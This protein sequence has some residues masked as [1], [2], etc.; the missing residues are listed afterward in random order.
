MLKKKGTGIVIAAV[1]ALTLSTGAVFATEADQGNTVLPKD[2]IVDARETISTIKAE[3]SWQETAKKNAK[4]LFGTNDFF[5]IYG[6][7]RYDTSLATADKLKQ[8]LGCDKYSTII[9]ASGETYPDALSGSLLAFA[10][11]APILLVSNETKTQDEIL[12]YIENN[13]NTRGRVYLLGGEG[14]VSRSFEQGVR[15]IANVKRLGGVDRYE[16][17]LAILNEFPFEKENKIAALV[18]SGTGF[19]DCLSASAADYPFYW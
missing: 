19:A 1:M 14:A 16:T 10:Y 18:C 5:R 17:N 3:T 7:D 9:M 4:R 12:H 13:L 11:E 8:C 2:C 6:E 15:R